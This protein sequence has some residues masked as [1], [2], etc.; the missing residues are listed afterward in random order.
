MTT[1]YSSRPSNRRPLYIAL[2][3]VVG[4]FLLCALCGLITA[5]GSR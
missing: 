4:L 5:L 1:R 2:A 3:T